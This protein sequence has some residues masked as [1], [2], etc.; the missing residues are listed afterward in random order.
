[1]HDIRRIRDDGAAID[2][3]L[4]RRGL[5]AVAETILARD[6]AW[7]GVTTELQHA[8]QR[9]NEASKQ[10]GVAKR[11]GEPADAL[12]AEVADLKDRM[13]RLEEDER[14]LAAEVEELLSAIPNLPGADVPVGADE[15]ANVE[16]RRVG[17]PPER[18]RKSGVKGKRGSVRVDRGGRR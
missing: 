15:D 10:I 18:E 7:R 8:Q 13:A 1:M 6:A 4:A 2:A 3:A 16:T 9:R 14:R 5:P 17:T 12:M 11:N